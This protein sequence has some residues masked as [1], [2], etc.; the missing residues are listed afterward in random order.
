MYNVACV[1]QERSLQR[2]LKPHQVCRQ[3]NQ[4][5]P[6]NGKTFKDLAW[7]LG[8][9]HAASA[10]SYARALKGGKGFARLS[11][12]HPDHFFAKS[13]KVWPYWAHEGGK[14]TNKKL[15]P[16]HDDGHHLFF[17]LSPVKKNGH[18]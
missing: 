2:G 12:G 18:K 15:K 17:R 8:T 5:E 1:I 16:T 7:L 11:R 6:W 9:K 13:Q 3:A 10:L 4:F 14:L